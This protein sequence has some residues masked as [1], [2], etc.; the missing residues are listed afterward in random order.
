MP[1]PNS[2]AVA[3]ITI[4]DVDLLSATEQ[5][6]VQAAAASVTLPVPNALQYSGYYQVTLSTFTQLLPSGSFSPFV[7]IRNANQSGSDVLTLEI[8]PQGGSVS[9]ALNI[10]PGGFFFYGNQNLATANPFTS[11]QLVGVAVFSGQ[12]VTMEYMIVF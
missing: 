2:N 10:L 8:Q 9:T 11:L 7:Y 3:T 4:Q 1:P 6:L 12:P 5:T